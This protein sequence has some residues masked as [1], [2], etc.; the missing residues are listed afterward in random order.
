MDNKQFA[1][2]NTVIDHGIT[3]ETVAVY[4]SL[5][6]HLQKKNGVYPGDKTLAEESGVAEQDIPKCLEQLKRTGFIT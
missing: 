2:G 1:N 4:I 3:R 5:S 6:R